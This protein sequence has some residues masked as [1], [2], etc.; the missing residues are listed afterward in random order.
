MLDYKDMSVRTFAY[1]SLR[2]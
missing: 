1:K 2:L